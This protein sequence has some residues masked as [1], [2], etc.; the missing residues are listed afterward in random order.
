MIIGIGTDIVEVARI[1]KS[2]E[3]YGERFAK[4]IFT[5]TE[6]EYSEARSK[7]KALHYAGRFAVKEAFSKAAG[8]GWAQG[9]SWTDV[10]V[11]NEP[12]GKPVIELSGPLKE[13]WGDHTIHVTISHTEHHAVAVV[14]IERL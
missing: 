11:R 5:E 3:E 7:T 12:S 14:V 13:K 8:T 2:L 6:R 4:K 9:F 10:G 1:A